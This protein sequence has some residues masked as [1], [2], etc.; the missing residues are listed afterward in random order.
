MVLS[1]EAGSPCST[2]IL[3]QMASRSA[4]TLRS[5]TL[6]EARHLLAPHQAVEHHLVQPV[7]CHLHG[8]VEGQVT[9][10]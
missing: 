8:V 7:G 4:T 3:S 1:A 2:D 5:V 9:I 6:G 10:P